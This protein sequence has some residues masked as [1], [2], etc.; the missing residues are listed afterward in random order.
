MNDPIPKE[1]K[2]RDTQKQSISLNREK[3]K[4]LF[5]ILD[6]FSLEVK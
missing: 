2:T 4:R 3:P 1:Q 6:L 5:E